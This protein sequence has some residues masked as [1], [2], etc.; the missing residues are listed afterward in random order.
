MSIRIYNN[1]AS[2]Y[3]WM[4]FFDEN[5][6]RHRK[7]SGL[8]KGSYSR[9]Q[10][11]SYIDNNGN[12]I[13]TPV[14]NTSMTIRWLKSYIINRMELQNLP[15]NTVLQYVNAFNHLEKA[16][17][18][19]YKLSNLN[20]SSV[21]TFKEYFLTH[22]ANKPVTI[23]TNLSFIHAALNVLLKE[24]YIEK[25]PFANYER[26][27]IKSIDNKALNDNEFKKSL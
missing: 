14:N 8:P 20:K 4:Y 19:E 26:L 5:G 21:W 10:A 3:W 6:K 12:S 13:S 17:G 27:K 23:N 16:F 25:N 11:Q 15:R 2:S 22:T 18:S 9:E 7:S 1:L 24:E